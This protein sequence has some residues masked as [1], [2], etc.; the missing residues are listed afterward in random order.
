MP[1][2]GFG[3]KSANPN[4]SVLLV[5]VAATTFISGLNSARTCRQAPHGNA[6]FLEFVTMPIATKSFSP[7]AIAAATADRSAQIVRPN[8]TFSTLQPLKIFPLLVLTA[9]PT[10]NFEYGA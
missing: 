4:S 2:V 8:D 6:G 9:A 5:V 1:W 7:A 3:S 10:V